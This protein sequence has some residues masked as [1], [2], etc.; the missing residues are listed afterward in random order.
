MLSWLQG[1]GK[2]PW[3]CSRTQGGASGSSAHW[4]CDLDK[5]RPEPVSVS[6]QQ[7]EQRVLPGLMAA[8]QRAAS[9]ARG[10]SMPTGSCTWGS[11][12]LSLRRISSQVRI[13]L[14]SRGAP[15]PQSRRGKF[16][17][18]GPWTQVFFPKGPNSGNL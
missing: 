12:F 13:P 10:A 4:V 8:L 9:R 18:A 5:S 17:A 16:T 3:A 14:P 7:E 2:Q 11:V 6:V 1:L 15:Y